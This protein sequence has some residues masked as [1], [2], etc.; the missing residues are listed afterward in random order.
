MQALAPVLSPH[1]VLTLKPSDETSTL[2]PDRGVR[3]AEAFVRGS[4]HG[5]LCLGVD[6]VGTTLPPSL[7]YWRELGT[8]YVTALC[9]LPGL[10][11]SR[12]EAGCRFA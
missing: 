5:L 4:G 2:D 12:D 9:A 1:G 3:I 6:E 11:R 7:A 8:R 10:G